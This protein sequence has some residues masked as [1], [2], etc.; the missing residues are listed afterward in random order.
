MNFKEHLIERRGRKKNKKKE[1]ERSNVLS[2][3]SSYLPLSFSSPPHGPVSLRPSSLSFLLV[4]S[5]PLSFLRLAS[6]ALP[7]LHAALL[8]S[9]LYL[10][11][12]VV[13]LRLSLTI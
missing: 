13:P 3:S 7:P 12:V 4:S 9:S 10:Q 5:S 11:L 6:S 8:P 2:P 1:K